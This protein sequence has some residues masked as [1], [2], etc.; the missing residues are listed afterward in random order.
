MQGKL[1]E[2]D[3]KR[4]KAERGLIVMNVNTVVSSTQGTL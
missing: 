1:R 4:G 2:L 3:E